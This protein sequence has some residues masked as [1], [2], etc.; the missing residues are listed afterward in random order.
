MNEDCQDYDVT[1]SIKS[2]NG[3]F[4][5]TKTFFVTINN[6]PKKK[7]ESVEETLCRIGIEKMQEIIFLKTG[8][9]I[10][11]DSIREI[12]NEIQE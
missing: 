1:V 4:K 3:E 9:T 11:I 6:Y 10:T 8:D 7:M 12:M 2:R 5:D